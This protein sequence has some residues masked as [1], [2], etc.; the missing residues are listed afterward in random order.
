MEINNNTIKDIFMWSYL[1]KNTLTISSLFTECVSVVEACVHCE[2][3]AMSSISMNTAF[4]KL[5]SRIHNMSINDYNFT[6]NLFTPSVDPQLIS[7]IKYIR[8]TKK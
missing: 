4:D 1:A 6:I 2:R 5:E 3:W 7:I 8:N